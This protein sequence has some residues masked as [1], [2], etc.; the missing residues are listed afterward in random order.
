MKKKEE[1]NWQSIHDHQKTI[2]K[3]IFNWLSQFLWSYSY[4][5]ISFT[6]SN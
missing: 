6:Y 3:I 5:Y 2:Q 1:I 4:I